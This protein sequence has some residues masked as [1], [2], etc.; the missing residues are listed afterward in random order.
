MIK[1][2]M[3]G[4]KTGFLVLGFVLVNL[5]LFPA[6]ASAQQFR[7]MDSSGN[8]HF[9]D[10]VYQVPQRYR[11][12]VITPTPVPVLDR[13][14]LADKRR[15]EQIEKREKMKEDRKKQ[16]EEREKKREEEKLRKEEAKRNRRKG[17][18]SGFGRIM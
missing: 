15:Q 7:Y 4:F 1:K 11:E 2:R 8:I 10:S 9:V 12:Q 13:K 3:P 5:A 16:L 14:Q 18:E 17:R 6:P